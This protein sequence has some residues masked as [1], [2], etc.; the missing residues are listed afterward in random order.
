MAKQKKEKEGKLTFQETLSSLEAKYGLERAD[1]KELT[2]VSTGS[3][4]LNQAMHVGGTALGKI[5]E[6]F[7][8]NSCG[9]STLCLHQMAEYQKAFPDK[10]V[11]L[12]DYENSFDLNY[13]EALGVDTD[14]LLIYQPSDQESGY[15]MV[16][17]LIEK[18]LVSC[19]VIDSQTA[20]PP[21]Q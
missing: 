2:I 15:N 21:R 13:A 1:P 9:K 11:A 4:Q 8:K 10:R 18:D 16:Q 17:A 6:V 14:K 12:F 7:G 5:V 3:L 19:V 20:A